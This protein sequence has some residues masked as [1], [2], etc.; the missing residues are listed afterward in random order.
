MPRNLRALQILMARWKHQ[1]V[2]YATRGARREREADETIDLLIARTDKALGQLQ[3]LADR[4]AKG[5]L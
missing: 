5:E 3:T 4:M 1:T 2:L